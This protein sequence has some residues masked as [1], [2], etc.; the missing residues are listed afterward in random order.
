MSKVSFKSLPLHSPALFPE[1]IFDRI[2]ENHPVRLVSAVVDALDIN[3]ILK[4]YKGGGCSAYHPRMMIKVLFYAYL[5][6]TYSCRKIAKALT[7]NIHFMY[8]SGN[9]TPDFIR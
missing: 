4:I 3:T 1:N 5:S 8:I 7:E 6:N 9:S 2:A